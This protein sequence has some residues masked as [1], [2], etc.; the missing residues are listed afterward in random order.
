MNRLFCL[1]LCLMSVATTVHAGPNE[2][3]RWRSAARN[4]KIVRDNWGIAHVYGK[5]DADAVFGSLYAQAEDDF[6]RIER[7]YLI[8]LGSLAQ[9]AGEAAVYDDLRQRLFVRPEHLKHLY[10]GA[11]TSLQRLMVAW[12]DGLNFYLSRHPD[13]RPKVIHHFEPW[14]ALSFTEGSIG[15]DIETVDL[16]KL[17][18][19]YGG[20]APGGASYAARASTEPSPG[21]SNGFAIAPSRSASFYGSTRTRPFIFAP[22]CRW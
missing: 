22:N 7:N 20:A 17:R 11:P 8:G 14:M 18:D 5:S 1:A 3:V 21:G 10:R 19:F 2:R 12:A 6:A 15:G 4:T 9:S 16:A 13:T